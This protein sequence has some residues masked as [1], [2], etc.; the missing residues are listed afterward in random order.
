MDQAASAGTKQQQGDQLN[1]QSQQQ[2]GAQAPA[3]SPAP[4]QSPSVRPQSKPPQPDKSAPGVVQQQQ[5]QAALSPAQ[6]LPGQLQ[7]QQQQGVQ[8]QVQQ[9]PQGQGQPQQQPSSYGEQ[10]QQPQQPQQQPQ[11]Q[12]GFRGLGTASSYGNRP[13]TQAQGQQQQQDLSGASGYGG[14][15]PY[16][17][18]INGGGMSHYGAHAAVNPY[19]LGGPTGLPHA[20]V[21]AGGELEGQTSYGSSLAAVS[22]GTTSNVQSASIAQSNTTGGQ[23]N[24]QPGTQQS[25]TPPPHTVQALQGQYA[26]P[27]GI[28]PYGAYTGHPYQY[29]GNSASFYYPGQV[30]LVPRHVDVFGKRCGM[31]AMV[32][33]LHRVSSWCVCG[34][35]IVHLGWAVRVS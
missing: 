11:Q 23:Y 4:V 27:P 17:M 22:H 14:A 19:G 34:W 3:P 29:Y 6:Q 13:G 1:L 32:V 24:Q 2:G 28:P 33:F 10:Q 18:G 21:G 7:P 30:I 16:A 35:A 20:G 8:Q 15:Y 9:P 31:H 26:P 25:P 5:G 12:G